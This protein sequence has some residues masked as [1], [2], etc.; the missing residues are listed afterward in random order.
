MA[1]TV[2]QRAP[3]ELEAAPL[4]MPRFSFEALPSA[5][6]SLARRGAAF[7]IDGV[8][9]L[10]VIG[11]LLLGA[12]V[13]RLVQPGAFA[14]SQLGQVIAPVRLL[15][16]PVFF[17]YFTLMEGRWGGT[18]GKAALGLRVQRA[19]GSAATML[20][21][22]VRN[23]LR[24]LWAPGLPLFAFMVASDVAHLAQ[25]EALTLD[26][27][28]VVAVAFLA[29]DL[30]LVRIGEMDQRLGDLAAGTVVVEG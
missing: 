6:P 5:Q 15:A 25:G 3:A 27:L 13:A 12:V 2:V 8:L 28:A 10:V 17:A 29:M 21:S 23:L 11:L 20:D 24:L 30:W 7:L 4:A 16:V 14:P 19:D 22:F 1:F 9:L 26:P 18:L